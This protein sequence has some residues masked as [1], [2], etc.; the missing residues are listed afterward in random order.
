MTINELIA[1]LIALPAEDRALPA[2]LRLAGRLV[3]VDAIVPNEGSFD[4][5]SRHRVS[6]VAEAVITTRL[7]AAIVGRPLFTARAQ[8]LIV[9]GDGAADH[10]LF[11]I[12][13]AAAANL[14]IQLFEKSEQTHDDGI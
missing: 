8:G 11:V 5:A 1:S 14:A 4:A 3:D 13:P 12:T 7:P 9:L 10:P 6:A 2:S